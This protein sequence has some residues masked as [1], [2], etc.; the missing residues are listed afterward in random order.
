[1]N[2]VKRFLLFFLWLN[3][4]FLLHATEEKEICVPDSVW[5]LLQQFP[6]DPTTCAMSIGGTL[7]QLGASGMD[8]AQILAVYRRDILPAMVKVKD[9]SACPAI[10][11]LYREVS[12]ILRRMDRPAE[13]I[14]AMDTAV[15]RIEKGD[16]KL[17]KAWIYQGYADCQIRWGN[18]QKGHDYFYKAI[19]VW[20]ELGDQEVNISIC[21]YQLAT[22]YLQIL[23]TK[24]MERILVRMRQLIDKHPDCIP[25][26][27][28]YYSVQ[29]A[30]FST[31]LDQHPDN[32]LFLDSCF[33][34]SYKSIG[35]I[36]KYPDELAADVMPAWNYF[37]L[38]M[39]YNDKHGSKPDYDSISHYLNKALAA[40]IGRPI[41]DREVDISV[42]S[43]Q[44]EVYYAQK[45][46]RQAE[47]KIGQV[48]ALL[49]ETTDANT[50]VAEYGEAYKL[51]VKIY[52]ET[53]HPDRALKYQKLLTE[54]HLKRFDEEKMTAINEVEV[55]YE[56]EKK[57][58]EITHLQERNAAARKVIILVGSLLFAL[59]V[60]LGLL[61]VLF[62]QRRKS[63]EQKVYEAALLAELRQEELESYSHGQGNV[64]SGLRKVTE[65]LE[66]TMM[67]ASDKQNYLDKIHAVDVGELEKLFLPVSGKMTA[68][69]MKYTL[70]FYINM[71][72]KDIGT[73][74]CVEPASVYTVRY[75]IRKKF[76]DQP[77]FR[78][79][80]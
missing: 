24:G 37:N 60:V 26:R 21:L 42:F 69:D 31:L 25:A 58:L 72:A 38:A 61:V 80:M 36:E 67:G 65:I 44:A 35:L 2:T 46:Y 11:W 64:A 19:K 77:A 30:R 57:E 12:I 62:R 55:K 9:A 70:C 23:D 28:D 13:E 56:V 8:D 10:A 74:F 49:D 1:M 34:Y 71:D 53:G 3:L 48:I 54:N 59:T 73:M 63:L 33:Y 16:D 40:K 6:S 17:R 7:R 22:G 39:M 27:Y 78:F 15:C 47:Q 76:K 52:E 43:L 29:M 66:H 79:L 41:Y 51:L 5:L 68:M 45:Q 18:I 20:E 14:A 4:P 32:T 50:L 75:R